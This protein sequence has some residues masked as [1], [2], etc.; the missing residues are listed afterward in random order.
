M[1]IS[2]GKRRRIIQKE[3]VSEARDKFVTIMFVEP[4]RGGFL[5]VFFGYDKT[6]L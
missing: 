1:E 3:G 4:V 2:E 5:C 6:R